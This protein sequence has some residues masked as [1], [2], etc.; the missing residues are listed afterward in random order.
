M[1]LQ[2]ILAA[3]IAKNPKFEP[4][5]MTTALRKTREDKWSQSLTLSSPYTYVT[6]Y[7]LTT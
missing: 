2:P 4:T 1:Y 7:S 3:N 5:S 6:P